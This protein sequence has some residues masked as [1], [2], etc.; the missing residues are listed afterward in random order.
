MFQIESGYRFGQERTFAHNI[1]LNLTEDQT[2]ESS[3]LPPIVRHSTTARKILL[4]ARGG[5]V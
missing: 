3:Y 5:L 4:R 2:L 1:C